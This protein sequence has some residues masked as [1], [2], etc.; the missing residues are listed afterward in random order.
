MIKTFVLASFLILSLSGTSSFQ[1][2]P[3]KPDNRFF[4]PAKI[5]GLDESQKQVLSIYDKSDVLIP[6]SSQ[7]YRE[8]APDLVSREKSINFRN[9]I[10]W[11]RGLSEKEVDRPLSKVEKSDMHNLFPFLLANSGNGKITNALPE[12]KLQ[13]EK[14][15]C[16]NFT[17]SLNYSVLESF[18]GDFARACF[19]M[20]VQYQIPLPDDWEDAMRMWHIMDPPSV[21]EMDRNSYIEEV[22]KNRNP[23]IDS[24]ELAEKVINF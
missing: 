12:N 5:I 13:K 19:Y 24:P 23:F 11:L 22:Q 3:P 20:S 18:K 21:W 17:G 4:K 16:A 2:I 14:V 8:L 7:C 9:K 1:K 15:E 6:K 10:M